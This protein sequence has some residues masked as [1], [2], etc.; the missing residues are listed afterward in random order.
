LQEIR[1]V[2]GRDY[3]VGVRI[4]GDECREGG[5]SLEEMKEIAQRLAATGLLDFLSIIG[6]SGEN[7]LNLAATVPNMTFPAQPFVHLA[8]AIKAV[9]DMPILHAQKIV[10]PVTAE[11]VLAEGWVDLVGMTRA[12]IADP[13]MANKARE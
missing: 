5:L 9:V 10:D 8:A 13:Q 4:T 2:V 3:T 12:Q 1:R 6:G 7:I 11:Q